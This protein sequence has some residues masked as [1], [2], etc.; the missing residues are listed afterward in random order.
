MAVDY[1][2]RI[3]E[4]IATLHYQKV[5]VSSL[6]N[7][8]ELFLK[9]RMLDENNH[10]VANL[11]AVND[12]KDALLQLDY[13][14]SENLNEFFVNLSNSDRNKFRSVEFKNLKDIS[15]KLIKDTL[16]NL[17]KDSI[18]DELE[19]LQTLRNN[20]THFYITESN[21]LNDEKFVKLHNLMVIVY[22]AMKD[23]GF[24]PFIGEAWAEYKKYDF[25]EQMIETYSLREA[26]KNSRV[27][28][29]IVNVLDDQPLKYYGDEAYDITELYF[30]IKDERNILDTDYTFGDVFAVITLLKKY[31]CVCFEKEQTQDEDW[32]EGQYVSPIGEYV[33]HFN[34]DLEGE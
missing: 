28:K 5:F 33:I 4:G 19:L 1:C 10:K 32:V 17:N 8:I 3:K 27:V 12:E 15:T 31:R 11:Y 6:H 2:H 21:Y 16:T 18:K 20:E 29:S 14:K 25:S 24:L 13:F 30:E 7:A 23:Y 22:Q 26:L 9:Q 34:I